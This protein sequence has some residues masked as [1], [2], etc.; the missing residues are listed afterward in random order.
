MNFVI[1]I[2]PMDYYLSL[3]GGNFDF[4]LVS[5]PLADV[6]GIFGT[7]FIECDFYLFHSSSMTGEDSPG[8]GNSWKSSL[9]SLESS[10]LNLSNNP[11]VF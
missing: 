5:I 11:D 6:L 9:R 7:W 4:V 3:L 8:F 10:R 2:P 1:S